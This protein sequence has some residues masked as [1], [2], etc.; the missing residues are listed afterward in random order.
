MSASQV[1]DVQ[2]SIGADIAGLKLSIAQANK[3]IEEFSKNVSHGFQAPAKHAEGLGAHIRELKGEMAGSIRTANF[4]ARGLNDIVPATSLAGEGVRVLISG[5]V[6]GAGLGLAI[7]LVGAGIKLF[8]HH[9]VEVAESAKKAHEAIVEET[10]ALREL[11]VVQ[12]EAR[13]TGMP[14]GR[15]RANAEAIRKQNAELDAVADKKA[16]VREQLRARRAGEIKSTMQERIDLQNKL[17]KLEELR[18]AVIEKGKAESKRINDQYDVR[19]FHAEGELRLQAAYTEQMKIQIA[20]ETAKNEADLKLEKNLIDEVEHEHEITKAVLTRKQALEAIADRQQRDAALYRNQG[21]AELEA[22]AFG[23]NLIDQQKA[24]ADALKRAHAPDTSG[25]P[26]V[27]GFFSL[28]AEGYDPKEIAKQQL[29]A[30]EEED[31]K[32]KEHIATYEKLGNVAGSV[33]IDLATGHRTVGE[34]AAAV[35]TMLL[36]EIV[37]LGVKQVATAIAT[38]AA[39][40][41][42]KIADVVSEAGVAGAGAAASVAS[43]PFVGPAMAAAAMAETSAAVLAGMLPLASAAGGYQLPRDMLLLGHKDEKVIPARYS[44]GLDR[45][46]EEAATGTGSKDRLVGGSVEPHF[47]FH[48]PDAV[49]VE[50]LLRDNKSALQKVLQEL[51]RAGRI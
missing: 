36:Q 35:G 21:F 25:Q 16:E 9:Q 49:G 14:E 8:H 37:Q 45:M 32:V 12:T 13:L 28:E 11:Q 46:V 22:P 31:K 38:H 33:L 27:G 30:I 1:G 43:I 6:G 51:A 26:S 41:P 40:K 20:Y 29:K 19:E 17:N 48:S 23:P 34:E 7:E 39:E 4:L 47:H 15:Q 24:N 42:V 10:K 44:K 3:V 18:D 2:L 5:L 50:R